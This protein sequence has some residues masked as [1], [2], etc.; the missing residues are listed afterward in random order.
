M[1][2]KRV[3]GEINAWTAYAHEN[4]VDILPVWWSRDSAYALWQVEGKWGKQSQVLIALQSGEIAWELDV[5]TAL[6]RAIL[7][8]T[9]AVDPKKF[10][11]AK[12]RNWGDGSGYPEKFTV[13]A[14]ADHSNEGSLTFP[15]CLRVYL[16]SN[17]KSIP[18]IPQVDSSMEATLNKDGMITVTGFRM[19][20]S[21]ARVKDLPWIW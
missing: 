3:L 21:V 17:P 1:G 19:G 15:V 2:T 10:L 11:E 5:L 6:Q 20:K 8:R 14:V 7:T 16:T 4:H 18:S 9:E 13:E 12:K